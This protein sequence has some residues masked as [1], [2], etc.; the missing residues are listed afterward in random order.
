MHQIKYIALLTICLCSNLSIAQTIS[1]NDYIAN[2]SFY[3]MQ[4][5]GRQ[6]PNVLD[7][8]IEA[9]Q[10]AKSNEVK[11]ACIRGINACIVQTGQSKAFLNEIREES[12]ALT[13]IHEYA[14]FGVWLN[15]P[16]EPSPNWDQRGARVTRESDN[17]SYTYSGIERVACIGDR[18]LILLDQAFRSENNQL[19]FELMRIIDLTQNYRNELESYALLKFERDMEKWAAG[20]DLIDESSELDELAMAEMLSTLHQY[21]DIYDDHAQRRW[22][23]RLLSESNKLTHL[24]ARDS[25]RI[26]MINSCLSALRDNYLV[27]SDFNQLIKLVVPA[28]EL[29]GAEDESIDAW[30]ER[31]DRA[32]HFLASLNELQRNAPVNQRLQEGSLDDKE[33]AY[34]PIDQLICEF[35]PQFLV[36]DIAEAKAAA[37]SLIETVAEIKNAT[38]IAIYSGRELQSEIQEDGWIATHSG[39]INLGGFSQHAVNRRSLY[40]DIINRLLSS[41]NEDH[42]VGAME[43]MTRVKPTDP[44]LQ[45]IHS[46]AFSSNAKVTPYLKAQAALTLKQLSLLENE[47][48]NQNLQRVINSAWDQLDFGKRQRLAW[49]IYDQDHQKGFALF[50]ELFLEV[51]EEESELEKRI[52]LLSNIYDTL[53]SEQLETQ[54]QMVNNFSSDG[55][56]KFYMAVHRLLTADTPDSEFIPLLYR[57]LTPD[58]NGGLNTTNVVEYGLPD[59]LE[60]EEISAYKIAKT[61]EHN[62]RHSAIHTQSSHFYFFA[63]QNPNFMDLDFSPNI[64]ELATASLYATADKSQMAGKAE[65]L[66][67]AYGE[68]FEQLEIM[69]QDDEHPSHQRALEVITS[70]KQKI[71][72]MKK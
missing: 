53:D 8:L 49:D 61:L 30:G 32:L 70:L 52:E 33:Y 22:L 35:A 2:P 31:R 54:K 23:T 29:V 24:G 40:N 10:G 68:V 27:R 67:S 51:P 43:L 28:Q 21:F 50:I 34:Y 65:L 59:N 36:S 11:V 12:D 72:K 15:D 17:K 58:S 14:R 66:L 37:I 42:V 1:V 48:S 57:K 9:Y 13:A 60:V 64:A 25:K 47:V 5:I 41:Q 26:V 4:Q 20:E 69:A 39:A 18:I 46:I 56:L 3:N 16:D 62:F 55:F 7:G 63:I 71:T 6:A 45:F 19:F 44:Q 38:S